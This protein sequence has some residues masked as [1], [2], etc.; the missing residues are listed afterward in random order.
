M[1]DLAE[2]A[3][4][5]DGL[6]T[7]LR[8]PVV[9]I[10]LAGIVLALVLARRNGA[11]SAVFGALGGALL[12]VDQIVNIWWV[13]HMSALARSAASN[14]DFTISNN[15]FTLADV[16]LITAA[17]AALVVA[18]AVRR[19]AAAPAFPPPPAF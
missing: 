4:L 8:L 11:I 12:A 17:G 3:P 19:R 6:Q 13:L 7:A 14:D 10:G 2:V 5:P 18:F 9:L 1:S 16:V 15:L